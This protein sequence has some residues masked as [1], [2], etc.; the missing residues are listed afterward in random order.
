MQFS[1]AVLRSNTG[2]TPL[3]SPLIQ[4]ETAESTV[5]SYFTS[6]KT[7]IVLPAYF[8]LHRGASI[9]KVLHKCST[10]IIL[11]SKSRAGQVQQVGTGLKSADISRLVCANVSKK[12]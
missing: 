8:V 4:H 7:G 10:F 9:G 2:I 12:I 1:T 6:C 5:V 11:N 3:N